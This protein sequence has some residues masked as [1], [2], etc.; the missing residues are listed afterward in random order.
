[1][2]KNVFVLMPFSDEY[3]DV[4]EFGIKDVAKEFNLTVTRLDEQIFDSDMLEQIYQQIEKADFIIAD[5]SGRNANVFYEVGYADAKKKLIILLTENI[6][7]I[8]FDLSHR[9]HVVYEKSLKKLKTDLR[10]RINWAIQ[11]IEKR[12]RNP[13]AINLKNKSSHVNRENATDTAIIEFTLEITNLTENKI[14]GLELIYLHTGP[15]WRFFMSSAEVKRMNSG[16]SPFLERHLLKPDVSILPAHDQL[17]IDFQGR[18][19]VSALWR[20]E[21]RKDSYPLQGRLF[22][23]IHTEKIEQKVVIFLETVASVP[24]YYEDI[25]F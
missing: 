4:Y 1:M 7:D 13:L 9:P 18:K 24:I 25:P 6:S 2:S 20:K 16:T 21:E 23:E 5:M 22:I 19:I 12:N 17:S 11:E 15:N 10:L 8:P 14:T 3:V